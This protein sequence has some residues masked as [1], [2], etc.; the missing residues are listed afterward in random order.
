MDHWGAHMNAQER[1]KCTCARAHQSA[2]TCTPP[3]KGCAVCAWVELP[4]DKP[5]NY[6]LN[7]FHRDLRDLHA[8]A[9]LLEHLRTPSKST[10]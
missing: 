1:T 3:Y 4:A 8:V 9:E 2:H 7:D 10:A 6:D 5:Q